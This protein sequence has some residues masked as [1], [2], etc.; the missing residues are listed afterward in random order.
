MHS[1]RM[2]TSRSSSH[3][4]GGCLSQCMLG[5]PP[6]GCGPGDPPRPDPSTSPW[7]WAWRCPPGVGLTSLLGVG[8]E[9]PPSPR[10]DP[11][12]SPLGVAWRPARHAWIPPHTPPS[13]DLL[14]S[15]DTTYNAC[16]DT[17]PPPVNRITDNRHV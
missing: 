14:Q 12:T 8:L 10:P 13:R 6:Y 1:S 17:N 15:W 4:G 16:W 2:R 5:C 7:V 9:N 11:S 3:R